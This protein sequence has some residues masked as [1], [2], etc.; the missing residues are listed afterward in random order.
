MSFDAP[1]VGALLDAGADPTKIS[2]EASSAAAVCEIALRLVMC[3]EF[4]CAA[5]NGHLE[6]IEHVEEL[7]AQHVAVPAFNLIMRHIKRRR[8]LVDEHCPLLAPL[9]ALVNGYDMQFELHPRIE[10]LL[11]AEDEAAA[12]T[13]EI[14][15]D[16]V[17][18]CVV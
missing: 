16:T 13:V 9:R 2:G 8:A 3:G 18:C 14:Q 4:A 15:C 12:L 6:V 11:L 1:V 7:T 10:A 17:C 5:S